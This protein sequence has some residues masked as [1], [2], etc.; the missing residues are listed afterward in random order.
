VPAPPFLGARHEATIDRAAVLARLNRQALVRGRWAM[1]RGKLARN[2]YEALLQSEAEPVIADL[3]AR[4]LSGDIGEPRIAR[5]WFRC[6]ADGD[7]LLVEHEG[8]EHA[9]EFPRQGFPPHLCIADF[10]RTRDEGGDVLG[11]FVVTMGE[12]VV[13]Q[14]RRL[15]AEDRYRDYL[16]LHGFAA[17][18]TDALA[19]HAHAIM[20]AEAGIEKGARFGLGYPTCP[21]LAGHRVLFDLLDPGAIGVSLTESM[22]LVP[23]AS[24]SAIVAHHPQARYFAV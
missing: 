12:A 13:E 10:F 16:M 23:V 18:L 21:D 24:T 20:R 3:S 2:E 14:A 5:G 22:E 19:D 4:F 11:T 8:R 6:R 9:L 17:E 7:R 1:R 15:Y